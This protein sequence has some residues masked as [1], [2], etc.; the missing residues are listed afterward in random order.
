MIVL[1]QA[2]GTA[3]DILLMAGV[4]LGVCGLALIGLWAWRRTYL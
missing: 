4:M 3:S 2:A 1:T